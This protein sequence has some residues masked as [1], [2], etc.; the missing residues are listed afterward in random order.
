MKTDD[1]IEVVAICLITLILCLCGE[2][3]PFR[4]NLCN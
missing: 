1:Q 4:V 2:Y 3:F